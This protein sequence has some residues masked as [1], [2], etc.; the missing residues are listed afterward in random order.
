MMRRV[1]TAGVLGGVVLMAWTLVVNGI[2]GFQAR[3]DMNRVPTER[4]VYEVLRQHVVDPGRYV[5]NPELTPEH[6]MRGGQ[7]VYSVLYSGM[8]H[9]AAGGMLWVGLAVAIS[10]S[11]IG[12]WLLSQ[13]SQ[14]VT[15]S[16]G[17]KVLFFAAVGLLLALFGDLTRSGIGGYPVGDAV[18]LAL[19]RVIAWVLAGQVVAWRIQPEAAAAEAAP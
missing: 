10:G 18:A 5:L 13:A 7:P 16:Y 3:I 15:A 8:G 19:H 12:A 9:E 11:V 4:E 1:L 17:R 2:F 6:R 14:R